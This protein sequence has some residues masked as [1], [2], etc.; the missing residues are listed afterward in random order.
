MRADSEGC[1]P[2]GELVFVEALGPS[3]ALLSLLGLWL[4]LARRPA[5]RPAPSSPERKLL[6]SIVLALLPAPVPI[7]VPVLGPGASARFAA[8]PR[9]C[10]RE[11]SLG[12]VALGVDALDVMALGVVALGVVAL[13]V[14]GRGLPALLGLAARGVPPVGLSILTKATPRPNGAKPK[15]LNYSSIILVFS[16]GNG[17]SWGPT[18]LGDK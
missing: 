2:A 10:F 11:V 9:F 16:V 6:L 7:L 4:E 12:V 5:T 14:A 17:E 8:G 18:F 1:R 15:T 13:G 3:S